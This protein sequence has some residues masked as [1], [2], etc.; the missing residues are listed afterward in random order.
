M[1][2]VDMG[3]FSRLIFYIKYWG[4][5]RGNPVSHLRSAGTRIGEQ[6]EINTNVMNFGSEPWLIEIGNRVGI[7]G[8][9][10]ILTH[11][12]SSRFFRDHLSGMNRFGNKFGTVSILENCVIGSNAIILPGVTVG[13]NSIIGAGSVV[14][15]DVLPNTVVAGNPA[16]VLCTL[17]EYIDRYRSNMLVLQATDRR[18]LRKELTNLLWGEER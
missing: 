8:G 12:G 17:E 18:S 4:I 2:V 5:H 11:D 6:V 9:V 10:V 3:L 14:T 15:K 13:P 7:A 16:R 1:E